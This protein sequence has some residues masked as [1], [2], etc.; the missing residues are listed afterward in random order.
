MCHHICDWARRGLWTDSAARMLLSA[1]I[2]RCMLGQLWVCVVHLA[3]IPLR[4]LLR[5]C[6]GLP[7]ASCPSCMPPALPFSNCSVLN[8]LQSAVLRLKVN[9]EVTVETDAD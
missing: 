7:S 5:R 3:G 8:L 2:A 6:Q 9:T 4:L 1:K